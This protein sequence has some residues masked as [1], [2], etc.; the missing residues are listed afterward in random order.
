V[1]GEA[2]SGP[3][4]FDAQLAADR[5]AFLAGDDGDDGGGSDETEAPV[6]KKAPKAAP[7]AAPDDE[8]EADVDAAETV[9]EDDDADLEAD[10]AED[11][12]D[13]ED[14]A[15]EA[16]EDDDSDLDEDDDPKAA[17]D[18]KVAKSLE[19]VRRTE[20][21]MRAQHEQRVTAFE[22][23]IAAKEAEIQAKAERV[24]K[25]EKLAA[26]AKHDTVSVLRELGLSDDDFELAAHEIYAHSKKGAEDPKRREAVA[27][28]RREREQAER[29]EK[30]ERELAE[31]KKAD[32]ER[33]TRAEMQR[34][35]EKYV[36]KVAKAVTD[37]TPLAKQYLAKA[38]ERAHADIEAIAGRIARETGA[39]PEPKA[40]MKE[41]ER[42]RRRILRDHGIDPKALQKTQTL[43]GDT[44]KAKA[45]KAA[46]A[47]AA[48]PA[49]TRKL[50]YEEQRALD[51][52]AF[53]SSDFD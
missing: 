47:A 19:Q 12:D 14:D 1:P 37:K 36:A 28:S 29:L 18:P 15:D 32:S 8:G 40:V 20:Q 21:R 35:A 22:Q 45:T 2:E 52:E 44:K 31:T 41:F 5:A 33:Q 43:K 13:V 48:D 23:R 24:E 50:T 34:E 6:A 3:L 26:R 39:I 30:L 46:A 17:V 27:R 10:E 53:I 42:E 9:D 16:D 25:F 51:R 49:S 11:E 7:K 4:T 38:P